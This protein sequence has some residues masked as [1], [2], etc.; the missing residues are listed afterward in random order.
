MERQST[1]I[2]ALSV[3]ADLSEPTMRANTPPDIPSLSSDLDET[4]NMLRASVQR[5]ADDEIAL[6]AEQIHKDN[7]FPVNLWPKT[8][9][10][11]LLGVT[12]K[13]EYGGAGRGFT[14]HAVV[15]EE[16]SR[17]SA[18]VGL[19]HGA[20]SNLCV[21]QIRHNGNEAQKQRYL[22]V[23]VSGKH[24]G[25]LAMRETGA[26]SDVVS[27]R[28]RADRNGDHY[29]LNGHKMWI[30]NASD[31]DSLVV[32]AKPDPDACSRGITAFIIEG[33]FDDLSRDKNSTNWR[34]AARTPSRSCSRI[35]RCRL[36]TYS[37]Q[38]AAE[39]ARS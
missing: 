21:N 4:A 36:R 35:A 17:A 15:M 14:E 37:T 7:E 30:T 32:Y 23:L 38:R 25:A 6:R 5:F 39:P 20:H 8:G 33:G 10:L 34:C 9:D 3:N 29:L 18:L 19:S 12:V 13:E 26:G 22:S 1:E 11:G 16:I 2:D 24:V 28:L 27:I 31:S